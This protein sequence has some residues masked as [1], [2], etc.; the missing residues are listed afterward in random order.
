MRLL[1][2]IPFARFLNSIG[3][4]PESTVS[5][6]EAFEEPKITDIGRLRSED[7]FFGDGSLE[8]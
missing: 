1:S 2:S 5:A 3:T 7:I 6:I 8:N 4:T